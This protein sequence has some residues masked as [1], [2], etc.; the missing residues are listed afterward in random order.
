MALAGPFKVPNRLLMG[1]GPSNAHPRV[2][3]A[4]SLPLLGHL[5]P[6][7][8]A[9]M[10]DIKAGLRYLFQTESKYVCLISG[11][12]HAGMEAAIASLVEPGETVLIGN[13]GIWGVRAADI[14]TRY[15]GKVEEI[16]APGGAAI[17]VDDIIAKVKAVK[18]AVLFL[19][20]GESSTGVQQSLAGVGAA[21][22]EAGTLLLVDS[23]CTLGGAPLFCDAW[24]VD[25]SYSGTQK[26]LS[27]PPGAAP[28]MLS[29]KAYAKITSRKTT[30]S[31]WYFDM[32]M[33]GKYWGWEGARFYHH[34]GPISTWYAVREALSIAMEEGLEAMWSRHQQVHRLLWDGL[35]GLGL[36]P[37]V[38][39]KTD[40]LA[41]VNTIKVPDGIDWLKLNTY[42]MDKYRLEIAGGL[43]PSAGKVWRIGVMG[44]N[45]TP[46]NIAVVLAAFKDGLQAQG[47]TVPS[48][49]A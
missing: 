9:I 47:Y 15:G 28:F 44:Y 40:R 35:T 30:I 38:E 19:C 34:T 37:F 13:N 45:A 10:D 18:P 42:V 6:P 2:L 5:H 14:A 8:L 7:F 31:S 4:Q 33:C 29:N 26:C 22:H 46:S 41:T 1:P 3:N 43:G 48:T 36:Q 20:Q 49:P 32:S 25:C 23:V 24:G 21:C 12:G 11:T 27:A 39:A 16:T 17:P